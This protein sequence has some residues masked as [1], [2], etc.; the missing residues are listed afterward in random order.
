MHRALPA[1]AH[2]EKK[3][4]GESNLC[5]TSYTFYMR[6]INPLCFG[7]GAR[8]YRLLTAMIHS[9]VGGNLSSTMTLISGTT[10]SRTSFVRKADAPVMSAVASWIASGVR[11]L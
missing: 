6:V 5:F 2:R 8:T 9:H 4:E 11:R 7:G 1:P 3:L 10:A